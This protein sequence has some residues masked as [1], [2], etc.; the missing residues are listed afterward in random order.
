M[1]DGGQ[2]HH[3]IPVFYLKQWSGTDGR[4]CEFSRP[5]KAIKPRMTHPDGAGYIRGL[6]TF[7]GLAPAM[8]DFLEEQFFRGADDRASGALRELPRRQP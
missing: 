8:V 3:Y 4:L 2:N 6:Y 5:Y 7:S 1:S